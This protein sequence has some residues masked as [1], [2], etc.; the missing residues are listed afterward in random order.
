MAQVDVLD[1]PRV[2]TVLQPDWQ[3]LS[4]PRDDPSWHVTKVY[5]AV[6][7]PVAIFFVHYLPARKLAIPNYDRNSGYFGVALT[8]IAYGRAGHCADMVYGTA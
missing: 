1:T 6:N 2:V 5:R 8:N 4:D 3:W 7:C